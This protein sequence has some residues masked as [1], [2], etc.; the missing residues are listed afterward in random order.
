MRTP[1]TRRLAVLDVRAV[2]VPGDPMSHVAEAMA[3]SI[4]FFREKQ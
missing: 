3:R 4:A 1:P 2:P